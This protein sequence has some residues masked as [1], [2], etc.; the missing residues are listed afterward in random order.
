[1]QGGAVND[2]YVA[3]ARKHGFDKGGKVKIGDT[4]YAGPRY[5]RDSV[6]RI[7]D[8][9]MKI[10][11]IVWR[12]LVPAES[13]A[14]DGDLNHFAFELLNRGQY[15]L[16]SKVLE[17][18]VQL[19]GHSSEKIRRMM[20]VNYANALKLLNDTK[21]ALAILDREDW[22]A[23]DDT[24]QICVAAVRE[25]V[26]D[27][28]AL[29]DKIGSQGA[30]GADAYQDWPVFYHVRDAAEFREAFKRIFGVDYAPSPRERGTFRHIVKQ[31]AGAT[32]DIAA[33]HP[34]L[35]SNGDSTLH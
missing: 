1:M 21:G 11:Q 2:Q 29:M 16:A 8:F 18:G 13:E 19:R 6:E 4:L 25:N 9:G 26:P 7:T 34:T 32:N 20:V 5:F 10:I 23:S 31:F 27:V 15:C 35:E 17:F 14:A 28:T 24:F 30:V 12:N 3:I 33:T 22:T